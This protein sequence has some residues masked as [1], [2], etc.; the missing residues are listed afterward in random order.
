VLGKEER[1]FA[2]AALEAGSRAF[3]LNGWDVSA[4]GTRFVALKR[5]T[6]ANSL[7]LNHAVLVS[8]FAQELRAQTPKRAR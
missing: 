3:A 7:D 8:D 1:L 5:E 2:V 6:S 4:D